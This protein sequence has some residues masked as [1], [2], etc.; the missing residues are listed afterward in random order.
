MRGNIRCKDHSLEMVSS[1]TTEIELW[2]RENDKYGNDRS[3]FH[4]IIIIIVAALIKFHT[5]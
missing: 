4:C 2:I 3:N 5:V 1:E